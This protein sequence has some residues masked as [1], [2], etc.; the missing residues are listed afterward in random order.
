[1]LNDAG[2]A[3][4]AAIARMNP[5]SPSQRERMEDLQC[6]TGISDAVGAQNMNTHA[7][8]RLDCTPIVLYCAFRFSLRAT[9]VF[10]ERRCKG[11]LRALMSAPA[12]HLDASFVPLLGTCSNIENSTSS[13]SWPRLPLHW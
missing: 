7:T 2:Q 3:T 6:C 12:A 5:H 4:V 8:A 10:V 9:D 11:Q 13:S 1:M